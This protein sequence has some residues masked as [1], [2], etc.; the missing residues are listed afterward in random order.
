MSLAITLENVT[1]FYRHTKALNEFSLTVNTGEV[2]ALLGPNGAGKTTC[3]RASAGLLEPSRGSVTTLGLN[4]IDHSLELK[5]RI[6]YLSET[7]GLLEWMTIA[8]HIEFHRSFYPEWDAEFANELLKEL[9][10]ATDTRI[11]TLS[12]GQRRQ[13]AMVLVAAQQPELMILDEP[14]G[15]LDP[16]IRRSFLDVIIRLIQEKQRTV[17]FSSHITSDVER[18]AT[19]VGFL[20]DGKLILEDELDSLKESVKRLALSGDA[21]PLTEKLN[22]LNKSEENDQVTGVVRQADPG[23]FEELKKHGSAAGIFP[24]SLEDIYLSIIENG[25]EADA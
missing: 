4:P 7:I 23:I 6:G 9:G 1:H 25:S 20:K 19:R 15:G 12:K 10:L 16:A 11:K 18:A 2:Y 21:L 13:V 8:R 22:W 24:L 14:A 17:I 5:Q 3:L